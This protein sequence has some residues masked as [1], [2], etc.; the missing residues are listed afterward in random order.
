MRFQ[1]VSAA[2]IALITLL[3]PRDAVAEKHSVSDE[4][5]PERRKGVLSLK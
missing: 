5:S 1:I 2:A 3:V 4:L